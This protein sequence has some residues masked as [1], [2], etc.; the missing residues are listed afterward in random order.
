MD[1]CE[2][3]PLLSMRKASDSTLH[4]I[5]PGSREDCC[6]CEPAVMQGSSVSR[7]LLTSSILHVCEKGNELYD[8]LV[9]LAYYLPS[10]NRILNSL[11]EVKYLHLKKLFEYLL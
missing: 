8:H 6:I 10:W 2:Q 7:Y 5:A 11:L 4:F 3:C 1:A 9:V